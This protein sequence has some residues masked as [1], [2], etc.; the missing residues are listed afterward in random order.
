MAT[1]LPAEAQLETPREPKRQTRRVASGRRKAP[2]V[3]PGNT[4]TRYFIGK[5]DG[6][7]PSL[8]RELASEKEAGPAK[9]KEKGKK[10][11]KGAAGQREMLLPIS[12]SGKRAAKET[13]KEAPKK[14]AEKPARS[15]ARTRKAG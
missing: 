3:D 13:A 8:E 14:A 10:P 7:A 4:Q 6:K 5:A 12:G 15:T 9:A 1:A 2:A 11:R